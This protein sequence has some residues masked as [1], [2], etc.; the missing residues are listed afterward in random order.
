MPSLLPPVQFA[1]GGEGIM[2]KVASRS[3]WRGAERFD[4]IGLQSLI[5]PAPIGIR[6]AESVFVSQALSHPGTTN[7]QLKEKGTHDER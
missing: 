1:S 5:I 6:C 7:S 2:Q 3:G 4:P